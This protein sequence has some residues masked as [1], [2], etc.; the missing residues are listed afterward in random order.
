MLQWNRLYL[1]INIGE[2][3]RITLS[4]VEAT[5]ALVVFSEIVEMDNQPESL[6]AFCDTFILQLLEIS[7]IQ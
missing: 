7:G 6:Q 1:L 2:Q 3:S 4:L 5:T